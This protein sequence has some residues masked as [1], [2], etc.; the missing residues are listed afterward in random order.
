MEAEL[1]IPASKDRKNP[2]KK[3][4]IQVVRISYGSPTNKGSH[5]RSEDRREVL[6]INVF[7]E[8]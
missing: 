6:F 7:V 5:T 4:F 2:R 8:D 1:G 3:E